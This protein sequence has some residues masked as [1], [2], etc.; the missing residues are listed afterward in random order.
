MTASCPF[1]VDVGYRRKLESS[2]STCTRPSFGPG[3]SGSTVDA[4][5]GCL[6]VIWAF[7]LREMAVIS[8]VYVNISFGSMNKTSYLLEV[9]DVLIIARKDDVDYGIHCLLPQFVYLAHEP[10]LHFAPIFRYTRVA[11]PWVETCVIEG[12]SSIYTSSRRHC[13]CLFSRVA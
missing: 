7:T 12:V 4:R 5:F 10:I 1:D 3:P 11:V 6:M 8:G 2:R 13:G 9:H